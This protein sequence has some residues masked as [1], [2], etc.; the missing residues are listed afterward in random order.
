[1]KSKLLNLIAVSILVPALSGCVAMLAGAGG[2]VLW[3]GG[4]VISEEQ[5]SMATVVSAVES[6]FSANDIVL[7]DKVAKISV[8][9]LRGRD[10][11]NTK[12]AVDVFSVGPENSKV[13]IRYGLGEETP[14]RNLLNEIKDRL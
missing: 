8:T 13:D 1:M 14:A 4:K 3:Q 10:L 5:E 6:A 2:T 11:N 9:Q 7:T 12:V